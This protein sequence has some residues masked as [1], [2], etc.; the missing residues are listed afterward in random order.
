MALVEDLVVADPLQIAVASGKGG[1][2]KTTVT[3]HLA[4]LLAK[5]GHRVA[6]CDADAETPNLHCFLQ[7]DEQRHAAIIELRPIIDTNRCTGCGAC[8]RACAF[9][10]LY[11]LNGRPQLVP[12]LCHGCGVCALVCPV[13]RAI[14]ELPVE[15]GLL[16]MALARLADLPIPLRSGTTR[17][18]ST[19][20]PA[21]I[22]ATV[23]AVPA[24][25]SILIR[26]CAPGTACPAVAGLRGSDLAIL[27]TE[28]TPFGLHDLKLAVELVR[29]LHLPMAVVVNRAGDDRRVQDWC[30]QESVP[31]V[32][33]IPDDRQVA[34]TY[35]DGRLA[36]E[37]IPGYFDAYRDLV[38]LV[39]ARAR[40]ELP[41]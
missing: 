22:E 25:T 9:N 35:A 29:N 38:N 14:A 27:V 19:R 31:V 20:T 28:A 3:L 2:G 24:D 40:Q 33:E 1:S 18:G 21:V 6:L 13:D 23:A 41:V 17:T 37:I 15:I 34:Q 7:L 32:A 4:W 36:G 39:V 8:S 26:D 12:E 30:R 16:Q 5:Q 10:A 11:Q